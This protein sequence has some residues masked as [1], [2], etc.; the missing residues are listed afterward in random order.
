MTIYQKI[1]VP[2][3]PSNKLMMKVFNSVGLGRKILESKKKFIIKPNLKKL[4]FIFKLVHLNKR[5]TALEFGSGWSTLMINLAFNESIK[6]FDTNIVEFKQN[7]FEIFSLDQRKKYL[8]ISKKRLSKFK[9]NKVKVN[10]LY[11]PVRMT[12]FQDR[13]STHYTKLPICNPDFIYLD[14]PGVFDVKNKIN[15]F[16]TQ[17][18]DLVPMS[19]DI[20]KIEFYLIPGTIILVDGRKANVEFLIKNLK[21]NWIYKFIKSIDQHILYLNE[22]PWGPK[23]LRLLKYYRKA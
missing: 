23:N 21:R 6:K 9:N 22:A 12:L 10:W 14:G 4:Y 17:N 5:L 15:N 20:L 7:K 18:R 11:S 13:I 19:C 16:S 1:K 2:S 3:I 8:S